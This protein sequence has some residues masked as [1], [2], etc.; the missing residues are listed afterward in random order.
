MR[1]GRKRAMP[2][3]AR[4]GP[5][6]GA[7]RGKMR[8]IEIHAGKPVYLGSKKPGIGNGQHHQNHRE[9][10]PEKVDPHDLSILNVNVHDDSVPGILP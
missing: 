5:R 6:L 10:L 7:F 3:E 1:V 9:I 4:S 2:A 8:A